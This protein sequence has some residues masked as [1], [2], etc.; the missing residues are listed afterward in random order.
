VPETEAF[1]EYLK[2]RLPP[3]EDLSVYQ[4]LVIHRIPVE[5]KPKKA[6]NK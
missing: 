5:S 6:K 3:S 1:I 4:S 2:K